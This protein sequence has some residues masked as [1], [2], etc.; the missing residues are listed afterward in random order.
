M[1]PALSGFT[2]RAALAAALCALGVPAAARAQLTVQG[3][4]TDEGGRPIAGV[5]ITVEGT[6]VGTL[7]GD[8]GAYRLVVRDPRPPLVLLARLVGF[9]PVRDTI[10]ETSGTVTHD[11]ALRRDVL[12]LSQVVV[13][14]T[15]VATERAKLGA[16]LSTVGGEEIA[17][18]ATPQIDVALAGKVAG[19]LVTPNSG[20]P[21]GGTSV[22]IRG[23]STLSRSAEPLYVV[24]G[25][26]VDNSSTQLV[27]LGGYSSNR[28]ADLD[29]NDIDHIEVVKGAAAAALYGSRANNGVVQ[30]FTKRGRAGASRYTLRQTVGMDDVERFVP[31]NRAPVNAAGE[32][33][34]R[35]DYQ[36]DI[37]QTAAQYGTTLSLSGGDERTQ[38]FLSGSLVDQEGVLRS[39]TYQRRNA[40]VNVDRQLND[41]LHL[42]VSTSY[43]SS[44]AN[45]TPNGGL[46][47]QYGVLTSFLFMSNDRDLTRDPVTGEFP[48]GQALANPLEVI[49]NWRAPQE[50]SRFIGGVQLRGTPGWGVT[51]DYRFGYD[52]YTETAGQFVP[53]NS[54]AAALA[55]GLAISASDR[56][57]LLN[58]DLDV[59]HVYDA[60]PAV[61]LTTSLGANWQ[62]QQYD[63]VTARA[64]DLALLTPTVQG[65]RQFA[66]EGRDDRRTL[67]FYAQEQV[68]VNDMLFL[69][70]ALRA[71]AASAFGS[72]ERT[73]YFPKF[74]ASFDVSQLGWWQESLAG[75]VPRLRLRAA[76]GYSGG[77]PAGSFDRFSNYVFEPSGSNAGAVNSTQQGNENLRPERQREIEVGAD[78]EF[79]GGRLGIEA[80]YFD[81]RISDL[82]LPKT[83]RPSSGFLSQL[84]NVGVLENAGLELLV[85]SVN[86]ERAAWGWNSS[87]TVTTNDPVVTQVSDGGA[88]FIPESFNVI[89]VAADEPPG[90]FFG[91]TY[92]R[93]EQG[94]ILDA[95][96][97]PIQDANG[98]IVGIPAIGPRRIIGD[99]NPDLYWSVAN[100]FRVG[101][102]LSFRVQV[103]GVQGLD[104]F[105]FDRRL[106]ETPAFGSG[107]EYGRELTGEVP[108]GYFQARRSIF[109]EYIEDGSFVK[110]R[111]VSASYTLPAGLARAV[112]ASAATLTLAGRNLKTWTDYTGWDPETNVGAQRT[113]VRGFSFATTPI[114][115]NV[116]LGVTLTF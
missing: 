17:E 115:R 84:A 60:T 114:P 8:D 78:A 102:A 85:R 56:A 9:R 22:R 52:T 7:A 68:G 71:D 32:P 14:G 16:T 112:R 86:V 64:E 19:A 10:A 96:D 30:I 95:N 75:A 54:S 27:D 40:R 50:V 44:D 45:L 53:R 59:S 49:A 58:S 29:P 100:D 48:K 15:G 74:G 51:V 79:L 62:R 13:T 93:D 25:V 111:E 72:E 35:H 6:T 46:V 43:I 55:P 80:T 92:V 101:D 88:F 21:G 76:L 83:V 82:I 107:A 98:D 106:L 108:T 81:K 36:D 89:R 18:A 99:P 103:D 66:S 73:Q 2:R 57:K 41:W 33:V 70:A 11:F 67:G 39:T 31:V 26:I 63:V 12:Q 3:R 87:V 42:G 65:S 90:H 69:T 109:E 61:R 104:V 23:L 37:F 1:S 97:V 24:D 20:T 94:R 91:T 47:A 28:L 110:L 34:T 4:V 77:Q 38:Y 5:Q 105:N 116:T 113:L